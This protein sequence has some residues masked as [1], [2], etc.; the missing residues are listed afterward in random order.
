[1]LLGVR[2]ELSAFVG[3]AGLFDYVEE[4]GEGLLERDCCCAFGK[5]SMHLRVERSFL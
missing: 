1:M 3:P 2:G 4:D 5:K